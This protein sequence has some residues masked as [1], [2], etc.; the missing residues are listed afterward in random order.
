MSAEPVRS[1]VRVRVV[2]SHTEGEPTRVVLSGGPDLGGGSLAARRDRFRDR[3]DEFRRAVVTEPRGGDA[4]VGALLV[5][6]EDPR[7][8]IGVIFFN[9]VGYLGMCGHGT[10]GVVATLA[11]L[12]RLPDPRV[13]LETPVGVVGAERRPDGRV[14]VRNVASYRTR[15]GVSVEVPGHGAVV[16]DVAWGGNWFFLTDRAPVPLIRANVGELSRYCEAIRGALR[17]D[18]ITGDGGAPIDHIELSGPPGRS[19]ANARNFVVCPGGAYDRSPCGTGTSAR[20]AALVEDGVLPPGEIW[21]QEGILG[22]VFEAVAEPATRGVVVRITGA[23]H[24]TAEAEL[25][26]EPG[27]PLRYGV[28]P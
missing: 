20:V 27:D 9:N 15:S 17:R 8:D 6:P 25:I 21:R 26:L 3:F 2:D 7:H 19:D 16:G 24:V 1:A 18:G 23:A 4:I 14:S 5:P 28:P 11:Y 10:I 22:T 12:G 13:E